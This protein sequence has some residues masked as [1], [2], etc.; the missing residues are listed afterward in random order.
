MSSAP[1]RKP[2]LPEAGGRRAG[3]PEIIT[4]TH[5]SCDERKSYTQCSLTGQHLA[6]SPTLG[7]GTGHVRPERGDPRRRPVHP[8]RGRAPAG[9]ET[10]RNGGR[11][12]ER[13]VR[14]IGVSHTACKD[15]FRRNPRSHSWSVL[16]FF[17]ILKSVIMYSQYATAL[18]KSGAN[19][20]CLVFLCQAQ[21]THVLIPKSWCRT[22]PAPPENSNLVRRVY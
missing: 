20:F 9:K 22:Y 3:A 21:E 17:I 18:M 11:R 8:G 10:T 4:R 2:P 13:Y 15:E 7:P 1:A 6:D 16:S 14:A 12:R 5:A 19:I